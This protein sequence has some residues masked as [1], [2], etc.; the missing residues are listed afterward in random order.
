MAEEVK[1]DIYSVKEGG[2]DWDKWNSYDKEWWVQLKMDL[3][4]VRLLYS[5][6]S[7]YLDNYAGTP[8]RP[9]EEE[10]YLKFLQGELYKMIQ[11]YNLTHH[12][13]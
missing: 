4:E 11:D 2:F 1:Q 9:P 7:F 5:T 6:I 8:E 10:S 13:V 12:S 3:K